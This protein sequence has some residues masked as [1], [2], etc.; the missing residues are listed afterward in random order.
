M[1]K[2][3]LSTMLATA[4]VATMGLTGAQA[5]SLDSVGGNIQFQFTAFDGAQTAYDTTA[6]ADG[7]FLCHNSAA[8]C[9]TASIA[10]G[11]SAAGPGASGTDDT[12]GVGRVNSIVSLPLFNNQ[13]SDGNGGDVLLA[14]FNGFTDQTVQRVSSTRTDIFSTGGM[15]DIYRIDSATFASIDQTNQS[16]ITAGLAALTGSLYLHLDFHT[17]CSSVETSAS[18]CGSFD[19]TTLTGNSSGLATATGGAAVAKY[20]NEFFFE[21]SVIPC[22]PS[23]C[24]GTSYNIFVRSG[25]AS[26]IALPEP[27]TLGLLGLGLVGL[28][29]V[30]RRRKAA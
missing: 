28:G 15:V 1:K 7:A 13:W 27:G 4:A 2:K 17:G 3:I 8:G 21:Q 26:T 16:T 19:L 23:L 22:N 6:L 25:S 14:Y 30:G 11:G 5:G 20:P 9:D 24:T 10:G 12:Y 18:L 29:L